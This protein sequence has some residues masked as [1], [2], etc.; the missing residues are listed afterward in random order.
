ML[1]CVKSE[2]QYPCKILKMFHG[3]VDVVIYG[4]VTIINQFFMVM[5]L[6]SISFYSNL[7]M[8]EDFSWLSYYGIPII[9]RYLSIITLLQQ[10]D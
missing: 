2:N 6:L 4:N 8:Y 7:T 1:L 10:L 3:Y 5:L 9:F